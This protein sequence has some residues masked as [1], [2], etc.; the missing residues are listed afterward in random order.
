[1]K[2]ISDLDAKLLYDFF[3]LAAPVSTQLF[4]EIS[5]R[6]KKRTFQKGASILKAGEVETKSNIVV[7]G[8]VHQFIFDEDV[9]VTTNITPKGLAFNSLKSYIDSSPS[10]E[11]QEA[12]TDVELLSIDKKD[13]EELVKKNTEVCYL[14][15]KIHEYILLDRENR[16]LLLQ[17]RSPSKRFKLFHEIVERSNRILEGTPDKYIASY[18]NMTPQQYSREKN[19][20]SNN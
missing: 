1:M 16:T 4:A 5:V 6:F 14:L 18:L 20:L 9:P 3:Q 2:T 13:L 10:L 19:K 7:K 12:I 17:Y 15:Y 8:V 11:I